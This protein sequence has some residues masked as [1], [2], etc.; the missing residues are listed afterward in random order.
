MNPKIALI[1]LGFLTFLLG[2]TILFTSFLSVILGTLSPQAIGLVVT[3]AGVLTI[4]TGW[5]A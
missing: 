5:L 2:L 3:V 4:V 1:I